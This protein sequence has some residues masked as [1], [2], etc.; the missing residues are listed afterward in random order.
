PSMILKFANAHGRDRWPRPIGEAN[1]RTKRRL[2]ECQYPDS[3]G[4][5]RPLEHDLVRKPA[6]TF[7]DH[8]LVAAPIAAKVRSPTLGGG[9]FGGGR[10]LKIVALCAAARLRLPA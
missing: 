7:P 9:L 3:A 8:A 2:S 4:P 6:S 1:G 5:S 10:F